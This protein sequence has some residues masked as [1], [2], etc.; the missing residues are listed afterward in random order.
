MVFESILEF[1][2]MGIVFWIVYTSIRYSENKNTNNDTC[3][4]V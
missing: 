2:K 3:K 1:P 4:E